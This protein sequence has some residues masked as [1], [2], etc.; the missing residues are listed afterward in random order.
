[1][2]NDRGQRPV[3]HTKKHLA[4]LER[5]RRQTRMI[6]YIF[7]GLLLVSVGVLVYGY[8]YEN[9]IRLNQPIAKV[10][11]TEISL[12]NSRPASACSATACCKPIPSTISFNRCSA[13]T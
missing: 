2:A 9:V 11:D 13:W 12:R 4:R 1:M 6:L 5:E 10:G 8:L 3:V 7:I